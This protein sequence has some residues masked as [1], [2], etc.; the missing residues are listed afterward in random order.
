[1]NFITD[2]S[3]L[4]FIFI[5]TFLLISVFTFLCRDELK[6]KIMEHAEKVKRMLWLPIWIRRLKYGQKDLYF[7]DKIYIDKKRNHVILP[8]L[9]KTNGRLFGDF[10]LI[11]SFSRLV[12]ENYPH[13]ILT[14]RWDWTSSK[15]EIT[16]FYL[17]IKRPKVY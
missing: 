7:Y 17:V 5:N 12:E 1:M 13:I 8:V 2:Y 3:S 10:P 11:D 9:L 14:G 15:E 16:E 4:I 6:K